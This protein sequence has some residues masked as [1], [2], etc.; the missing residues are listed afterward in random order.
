MRSSAKLPGFQIPPKGLFVNLH[1]L[2]FRVELVIPL[3]PLRAPDDL[4]NPGKQDIHGSDSISIIIL[5][6]IKGLYGG[7]IIVDYDRFLE[8]FLNQ[9]TL[10]LR[11]QVS[12]P[13]IN[14]ELE[15][16]FLVHEYSVNCGYRYQ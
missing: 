14:R 2:N 15:F 7:W 1:F 12:S 3:F 6:H 5:T 10:M 11:L 9:I 4:T 13:L 16:L 8:V